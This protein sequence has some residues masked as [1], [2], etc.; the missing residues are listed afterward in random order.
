MLASQTSFIDLTGDDDN[1]NTSSNNDFAPPTLHGTNRRSNRNSQRPVL[2]PQDRFDEH[3]HLVDLELMSSHRHLSL[4]STFARGLGRTLADF[5]GAEM[6]NSQFASAARPPPHRR[7]GPGYNPHRHHHHHQHHQPPPS[8]RQEMAPVPPARQGFTRD[9]CA[10][11][12]DDEERVVVCPACN[13]E[14]AYDPSGG[15]VAVAPGGAK[16]R[17][18]AAGDHHFWAIK[19]CGHVSSSKPCLF[20]FWMCADRC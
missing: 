1:N 14:L 20:F 11:P 9:T 3:D 12:K 18:R 7:P 6:L 5:L 2:P 16:K 13:E 8:P 10:E 15:A 17:K 19:K 4:A